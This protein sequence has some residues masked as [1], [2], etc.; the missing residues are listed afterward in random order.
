[1]NYNIDPI[2]EFDNNDFMQMVDEWEQEGVVEN[3]D[4]ETKKLLKEF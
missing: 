1:M 4:M 2:R 3:L